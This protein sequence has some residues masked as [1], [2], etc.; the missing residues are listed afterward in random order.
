MICADEFYENALCAVNQRDCGRDQCNSVF[1]AIYRGD[2]Q[3]IFDF[4][5]QPSKMLLVFRIYPF[6]AAI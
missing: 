6:A 2:S 5:G 4:A 1:R 3:R